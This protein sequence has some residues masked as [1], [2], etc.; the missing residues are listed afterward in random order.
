ML[1]SDETHVKRLG[2]INISYYTAFYI[3]V[4]SGPGL[5]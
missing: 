5:I 2:E 4:E 3:V 1:K